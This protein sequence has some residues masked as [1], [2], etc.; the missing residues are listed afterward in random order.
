MEVQWKA[1]GGRYFLVKPAEGKSY[2]CQRSRLSKLL[3]RLQV[4]SMGRSLFHA[5]FPPPLFDTRAFLKT[6]R[7][8]ETHQGSEL[9]YASC[10]PL[11]RKTYLKI[12][13]STGTNRY[14]FCN[15]FIVRSFLRRTLGPVL[16]VFVDHC[17]RWGGDSLR[18]GRPSR[19]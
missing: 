12:N 8:C 4:C 18:L 10:S 2:E 14:E 5:Y 3:M 7:L 9:V 15:R 13:I 1:K 16:L 17:I 19:R 11:C 6:V